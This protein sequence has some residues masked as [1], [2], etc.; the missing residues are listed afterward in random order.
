M[1]QATQTTIIILSVTG[2]MTLLLSVIG[3]FMKHLF[4]KSQ[5]SQDR[6]IEDMAK[7]KEAISEHKS[8]TKESAYKMRLNNDKFQNKIFLEIREIH[9]TF[10]RRFEK[11][12]HRVSNME[13]KMGYV[14]D[15]IRKRRK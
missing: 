15:E 12:E 5:Y 8:E 1:E 11:V 9:D 13:D 6:I 4:N 3:F 2:I 7:N 10:S 14:T